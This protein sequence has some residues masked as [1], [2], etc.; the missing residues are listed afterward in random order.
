MEYYNNILCISYKELTDGIASPTVVKRWVARGQVKVMRRVCYG[1]CALYEVESIPMTDRMEVY[2]RRNDIITDYATGD[3]IY[4]DVA[5]ISN[6]LV[7]FISL[8]SFRFRIF[9]SFD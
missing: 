5:N 8:F 2:R 3:K 6:Q 4:L 9:F 1:S 7:N